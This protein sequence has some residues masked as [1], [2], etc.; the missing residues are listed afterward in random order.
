MGSQVNLLEGF[1]RNDA[2]NISRVRKKFRQ[3]QS[4][5]FDYYQGVA[6]GGLAT[7]TATLSIFSVVVL[8]RMELVAR[9]VKCFFEL[10]I[11]RP[12]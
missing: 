2:S 11:V 12:T 8:E 10:I 7:S 1:F 9:A 5:L 6:T 4:F 3:L